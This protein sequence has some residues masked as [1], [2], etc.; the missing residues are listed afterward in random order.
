MSSFK[1]LMVSALVLAC[2]PLA[3]AGPYD[4][5]LKHAPANTNAIVLIDVTAA[6]KTPLGKK[7]KWGE[8]LEQNGRGGL[9]FFPADAERVAIAAEVN[10]TS[11]VRDFQVGL[12]K[13]KNM[14]N[15]KDLAASEGGA[16]DDIAGQ[17]TVVTPRNT[18]FTHFPGSTLAAAFPGDRQYVSRWLKASKANK[19]PALAPYLRSAA[20]EASR[21]V[22]IAVDLE[23]VVD[24]SALKVGLSF[25]P[26][27]TKNPNVNQ[28]ALAVFIAHAKGLTFE[29]HITDRVTGTLTIVFSDEVSRYKTV[30]KELFLELLDGY[31]VYIP[32]L[33]EWHATYIDN[34]MTLSGPLAPDDL[35][36]VVSLFSFPQLNAED[37]APAPMDGPNASATKRYMAAV[38]VI[39]ADMKRVKDSTNYEKTATWHDKAALQL[40]QLGQ[41]GVD[42]L[43]VD[44]AYQ[45]A[46]A[47]RAVALSLRGVPIDTDAISQKA[48]TITQTMPYYGWGP[49]GGGWWGGYRALA[50]APKSFQT[51]IPQVQGEIARTIA[52]DQK[53]RIAT[54]SALDQLMS[55]TKRKLTDKYKTN[56]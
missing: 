43:A 24:P 56:F 8:Q 21:V 53:K 32:G 48:Y 18:Y 12:V 54:W 29:A 30:L 31:G 9:G 42:P 1:T 35:K 45:S 2:A 11:M 3:A 28:S 10:L 51:N 41:R 14:P 38:G 39:L 33:D 50:F 5:L 34:K 44:A 27:M 47:M 16:L 6:A 40:E 7:E 13:V 46:R 23:D 15:F 22:T 17:L 26:V 36:R 37:P 52:N 25:S 4:D 20:D 55:D 49:Y 19:L